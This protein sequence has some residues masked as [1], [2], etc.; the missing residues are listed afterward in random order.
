MQAPKEGKEAPRFRKPKPINWAS[1]GL[2][3]PPSM[4]ESN[5]SAIDRILA[6]HS[7]L[8]FP[9]ARL[10]ARADNKSTESA[11]SHALHRRLDA[12]DCGL[13]TVHTTR[14]RRELLLLKIMGMACPGTGMLLYS[15]WYLLLPGDSRRLIGPRRAH[16]FGIIANSMEFQIFTDARDLPSNYAAINEI[17]LAYS[18]HY[19]N[20]KVFTHFVHQ[21]IPPRHGDDLLQSWPLRVVPSL[22]C[23][24]HQDAYRW[25]SLDR[26]RMFTPTS[27]LIEKEIAIT[28][29]SN[30]TKWQAKCEEILNVIQDGRLGKGMMLT[31]AQSAQRRYADGVKHGRYLKPKRQAAVG[32]EGIGRC[33]VSGT[34]DE[35]KPKSRNPWAIPFT[36]VPMEEYKGPKWPAVVES[37]VEIDPNIVGIDDVHFGDSSIDPLGFLFARDIVELFNGRE[38]L[39]ASRN[40][41]VLAFEVDEGLC[42]LMAGFQPPSS[43]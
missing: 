12:L 29:L 4:D 32:K 43:T 2:A 1:L 22:V 40:D 42:D 25:C 8:D 14:V 28:G 41:P 6:T 31:E 9:T 37:L 38:K 15:R 19:P 34:P 13:T 11:V 35:G 20:A 18:T 7:S 30:W 23:H 16:P 26:V 24:W 3:H 5:R 27:S 17:M 39:I 33:A 21:G 10:W 36:T